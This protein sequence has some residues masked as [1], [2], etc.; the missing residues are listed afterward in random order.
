[1][2]SQP[3]PGQKPFNKGHFPMRIFPGSSH[4]FPSLVIRNG[5]PS[6]HPPTVASRCHVSLTVWGERLARVPRVHEID[7][8]VFKVFDVSGYQF[9]FV[10]DT[11]RCDCSAELTNWTSCPSPSRNY[12]CIASGCC[13]GESRNSS[14]A[15]MAD[16]HFQ[17]KQKRPG[18]SPAVRWYYLFLARRTEV[19]LD[20]PVLRVGGR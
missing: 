11:A 15:E 4:V 3:T 6:C 5:I 16:R 7:T 2:I 10:F 12:V 13:V 9:R 18:V 14:W 17:G 20:G 8:E 19:I 1:V